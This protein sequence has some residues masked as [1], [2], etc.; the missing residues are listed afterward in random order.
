MSAC[1]RT[2]AISLKYRAGGRSKNLGGPALK[3]LDRLESLVNPHYIESGKICGA[4]VPLAP[5]Q[6]RRP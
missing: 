5:P 6:F 4:T 1:C 3:D 2:A